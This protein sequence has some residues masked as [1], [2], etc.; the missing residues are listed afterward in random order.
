MLKNKRTRLLSNSFS[1]RKKDVCGDGLRV[2]GRYFEKSSSPQ[3]RNRALAFVS[4]DRDVFRMGTGPRLFEP[5]SWGRGVATGCL[6]GSSMANGSV[7]RDQTSGESRLASQR[8]FKPPRDDCTGQSP[9]RHFN[10][11]DQ[12][13]FRMELFS[14]RS[15]LV[16][17]ATT[18]G[19]GVLL[20]IS[21]ELP[22]TLS[23]TEAAL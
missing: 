3:G 11:L 1:E 7:G 6:R 20:R 13:R 16:A 5:A 17:I 21:S 8:E 10:T 18:L 19:D 23:K 14:R 15:M 4:K 9:F 2:R 12:Q 22:R